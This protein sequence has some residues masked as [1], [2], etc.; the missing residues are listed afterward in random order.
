MNGLLTPNTIET[1]RTR[2][3]VQRYATE[4]VSE[5]A[6]RIE[7]RDSRVYDEIEGKK[8]LS[9]DLTIARGKT[10]PVGQRMRLLNK[11]SAQLSLPEVFPGLRD[12][13]ESVC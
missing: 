5:T 9:H 13:D 11:F 1:E 6:K 7:A 10:C 8:V 4:P 3:F 2:R 12:L